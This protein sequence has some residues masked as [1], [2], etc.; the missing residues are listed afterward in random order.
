MRSL[1]EPRLNA[2]LATAREDAAA[3]SGDDG[4]PVARAMASSGVLP[5]V[6]CLVVTTPPL[7]A[8]GVARPAAALTITGPPAGSLDRRR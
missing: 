3:T 2:T 4:L 7:A 6:T 1:S 8:A 5:A